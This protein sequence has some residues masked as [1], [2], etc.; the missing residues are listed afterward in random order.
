MGKALCQPAQSRNGWAICQASLAGMALLPGTFWARG[1]AAAY[2]IQSKVAHLVGPHGMLRGLLA[3]QRRA[4]ASGAC[5]A[6]GSSCCCQTA[7]LSGD[8]RPAFHQ[9]SKLML[10]EPVDIMAFFPC[11]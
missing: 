7:A 6:R 2:A 3:V 5:P 4:R 10:H 8:E 11:R 1:T 9:Q